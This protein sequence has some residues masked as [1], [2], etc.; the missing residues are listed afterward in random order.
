MSETHQTL[1]PCHTGLL[2]LLVQTDS[3]SAQ[4]SVAHSC[5][6]VMDFGGFGKRFVW[7]PKKLLFVSTTTMD[8]NAPP[9]SDLI[10]TGI[11]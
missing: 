6:G 10:G 7:L 8:N 5:I 11:Y 1:L 2:L 4:I 9:S 3:E